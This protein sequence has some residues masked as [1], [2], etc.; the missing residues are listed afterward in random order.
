MADLFSERIEPSAPVTAPFVEQTPKDS[1]EKR[2]RPPP[3]APEPEQE[4]VEAPHHELDSL[5]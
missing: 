4:E 3:P 5:A 1:R 2:R